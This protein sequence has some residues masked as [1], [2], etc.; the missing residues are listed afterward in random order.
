MDFNSEVS[1]T[2][3]ACDHTAKGTAKTLNMFFI[4]DISGS[5]RS[6]GKIEAVNEAFRRMIPEL[7]KIQNDSLSE[8]ELR[9]AIMTFDQYARWIVAPTPILEYNFENI[10]AS[11][12]VTYFSN[13]YAT[14]GEKLTRA[15][16]MAHTGKLAQPYIMMLTDGEPTPDDNFQPALNEL[17]DNGW[18]NTAQR[19]AV[20]IGPD[21]VHSPT[22]REAVSQFVSDEIEGIINAEDAEEIVRSVQAKTIHTIKVATK[23]VVATDNGSDDGNGGGW[24]YGGSDQGGSQGSGGGWSDWDFDDGNSGNFI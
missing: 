22:A 23:H 9:I 24:D 17:L 6:D 13:A 12:W 15:E 18:F 19:F 16:Y 8:F 5:M 3:Q 1:Q 2:T 4:V 20:L 14:F 7:K 11:E 10:E 21:V